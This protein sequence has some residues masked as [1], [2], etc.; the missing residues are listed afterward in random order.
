MIARRVLLVALL[1]VLLLL[2]G[3]CNFG[4]SRRIPRRN[5]TEVAAGF[6]LVGPCFAPPNAT[7]VIVTI[8][9]E[10]DNKWKPYMHDN[11]YRYCQ[12]HG[13]AYCELPRIDRSYYTHWSK[14]LAIYLLL[15]SYERVIWMDTDILLSQNAPSIPE[16]LQVN[17]AVSPQQFATGEMICQEDQGQSPINTGFVVFQDT[18][19][20]RNLLTSVFQLIVNAR[21]D[22]KMYKFHEQTGFAVVLKRMTDVDQSINGTRLI[23]WPRSRLNFLTVAIISPRKKLLAGEIHMLHYAGILDREFQLPKLARPLHDDRYVERPQYSAELKRMNPLLGVAQYESGVARVG[24]CIGSAIDTQVLL[25]VRKSERRSRRASAVFEEYSLRHGYAFCEFERFDFSR[26]YL[27]NVWEL[28]IMLQNYYSRVYWF[29]D[30]RT[31]LHERH[32]DSRLT[33]ET[34]LCAQLGSECV[35]EDPDPREMAGVQVMKPVC[36]P[37]NARAVS[38][39]FEIRNRV[40]NASHTTFLRLDQWDQSDAAQDQ[41]HAQ[42]QRWALWNRLMGDAQARRHAMATTATARFCFCEAERAKERKHRK[43]E[44]RRE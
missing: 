22:P 2:F 1:G 42:N 30:L 29:R 33:L 39:V 31:L 18:P 4:E 16:M 9:H 35:S 36:N 44:R 26:T 40:L 11:R 17:D 20:V 7:F 28:A 13:Y 34:L 32:Q 25:Y 43:G 37:R 38:D 21:G 14:V 41:D 5:R 3:G 12:R 10:L 27:E 8:A 19:W 23:V 24:P 15:S 6:H